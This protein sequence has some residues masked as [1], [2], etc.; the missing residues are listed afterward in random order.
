MTFGQM[1]RLSV[2][3]DISASFSETIIQFLSRSNGPRKIFRGSTNML[4]RKSV[5]F[6][7]SWP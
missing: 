4:N 7:L 6:I 1:V 2:V 5:V 3:L